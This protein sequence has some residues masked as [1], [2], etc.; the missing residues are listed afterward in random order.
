MGPNGL[1]LLILDLDETL[2]HAT[3]GPLGHEPDFAVGP[4]VV[5]RRPHLAEFL[6]D[7]SSSFRLAV[8]SSASDDYVRD[9]VGQ[10]IPSGIKL[11]FAWGRSQCVR[12]L[13]PESYET[14]YLK[15]LKK[16]KRL[17]YDLRLVLIL[18]D[19]PR[20]VRRH[21]GNAVYVPPF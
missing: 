20:K 16:V 13:D 10:I 1:M 14:D 4:Y 3:E 5:S 15:D 6:A 12:R 9:V 21:Y 11:A 18:D 17:G 7:C 2:I 19:T 8:W